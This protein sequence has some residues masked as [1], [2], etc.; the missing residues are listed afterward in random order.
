MKGLGS[1]LRRARRPK[2]AVG[3][4]RMAVFATVAMFVTRAMLVLAQ[5][6]DTF[7]SGALSVLLAVHVQ[8]P[9][10]IQQHFL[11]SRAAPAFLLQVSAAPILA[12]G[13]GAAA[14]SLVPSM[15]CQH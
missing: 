12:G 4:K 13:G 9:V 7:K 11:E 2:D 1:R 14:P 8:G 15:S 5:S 6:P 3:S 10:C